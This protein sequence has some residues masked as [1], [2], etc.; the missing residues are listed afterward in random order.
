M[1]KNKTLDI[2]IIFKTYLKIFKICCKHFRFP[3]KL[4]F[5][6]TSMNNFQKLL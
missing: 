3:N 1:I 4:L 2:K 5:Y 6:K